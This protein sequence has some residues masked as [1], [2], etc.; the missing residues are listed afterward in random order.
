MVIVGRKGWR[1]VSVTPEE[2]YIVGVDIGQA[3]DP[4]AICVLHHTV[5]PTGEC[6]IQYGQS[7]A[8]GLVRERAAV[9][10]DVRH[11]ER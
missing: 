9:H 6:T 11:L 10:F 3:M 8:P 7:G 5:V 4:T 2:R 1:R